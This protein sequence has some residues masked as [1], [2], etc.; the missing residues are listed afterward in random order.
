MGVSDAAEAEKH[1][2]QTQVQQSVVSVPW[3]RRGS[4]RS[5]SNASAPHSE[6]YLAVMGHVCTF[7]HVSVLTL[8]HS[9]QV[10]QYDAGKK[11]YMV[12][13]A[14]WIETNKKNH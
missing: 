8:C 12:L 1:Q 6:P 13:L 11:W 10:N 14:V 7:A 5:I 3:I 9:N 2:V 4:G